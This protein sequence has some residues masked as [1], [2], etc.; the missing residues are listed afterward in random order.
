[1]NA[2]LIIPEK[3]RSNVWYDS[4]PFLEEKEDGLYIKTTYTYLH[5]K[6][7]EGGIYAEER[8]RVLMNS[9]FVCAEHCTFAG[10]YR[11]LIRNP[12]YGTDRAVFKVN[13]MICNKELISYF[14]RMRADIVKEETKD[15]V[16]VRL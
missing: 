6:T 8:R 13:D 11:G 4:T 15:G 5:K 14:N 9:P 16:K 7:F 3:D 10:E 12:D 1:M 2:I